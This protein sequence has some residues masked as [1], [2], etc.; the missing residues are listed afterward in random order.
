VASIGS[1]QAPRP[2]WRLPSRLSWRADLS[3]TISR[4]RALFTDERDVWQYQIV[5]ESPSS[6]RVAVVAAGGADLAA[7]SARIEGALTKVVGAETAL[8]VDFVDE[9]ERTAHGKVR[10]VIRRGDAAQPATPTA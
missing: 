4:L 6:L 2:Y 9:L 5:Q 1:E 7:L 8:T 3:D 10:A